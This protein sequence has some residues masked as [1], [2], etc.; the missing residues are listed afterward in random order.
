MKRKATRRAAGSQKDRKH[1]QVRTQAFVTVLS[2][3]LA[4]PNACAK[5]PGHVAEIASRGAI[6]LPD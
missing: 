2:A 4:T 1:Q 3:I 5:W 6:R